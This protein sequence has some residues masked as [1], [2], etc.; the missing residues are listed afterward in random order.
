MNAEPLPLAVLHKSAYLSL[1]QI[2]I[3]EKNQSAVL[4]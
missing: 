2:K 1:I 4:G 3:D